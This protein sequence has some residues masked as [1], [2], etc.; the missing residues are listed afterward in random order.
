VTTHRASEPCPGSGLRAKVLTV[1]D[2]VVHGTRED[3]SGVALVERLRTDGYDVVEHRVVADGRET[4][5]AALV[6]MAAAFS[7][8]VVSTGG[9]GFAPRDQTPEGTS[10]VIEREAPGLAEA[11]RLVSPLGRL[12]RGVVGIRGKASSAT[13]RARR[14]AASSSSR[15][16]STCCPTPCASW[17]RPP[18]TTDL[19]SREVRGPFT[20]RHHRPAVR[21]V[22]VGGAMLKL[23]LPKGSLEKATLELFEAADLPVSRSSSVDYKATI[24]DPRVGRCA[25]CGPQ[26]IPTYVAEGLFDIGITGRDWVEETSS[27]IVSLTEL[28]LLQGHQQPHAGRGGG[29]AGQPVPRR[30]RSSPGRAGVHRVPRADPPLLRRPGDRCRDP[31]VVRGER[32]E[33]PRHRRLHRRHHRDR[34]GAAGRR[35]QDHRHDPGVATPSSSPTGVVRGPGEAPRDGAADDP[36]ARHARRPGQ[37]AREDERRR[38]GF[39]R[40]IE[41]LPSAKSPTV[42]QLASAAGTPSRRW[43]RSRRSTC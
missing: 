43:C 6:S 40:V 42:A 36:A 16:F 33:D 26:E 23:V 31:A 10:L 1:S 15:P 17:R 5:A 39:D 32:G 12:S 22:R 29:G 13:P 21:F 35:A 8:V 41:L 20:N 2:G 3:R 30:S 28:K 24:A 34:S 19:P 18:P 37:G 4:V 14:R 38:R 9:T 11:M 25:S 27:D 7:G